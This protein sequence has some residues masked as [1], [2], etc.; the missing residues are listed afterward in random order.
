MSKAAGPRNVSKPIDTSA[1]EL[2]AELRELGER[3]AEHAHDIYSRHRLAEGWCYGL[4]RN[5]ATKENPTLVP[6]ADLPESEKEYDRQIVME[7][8][9]A[10]IALEYSIEKM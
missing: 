9:K 5:D 3:L 8:L 1:V 10:M 7:T 6:Y 4:E 2:P